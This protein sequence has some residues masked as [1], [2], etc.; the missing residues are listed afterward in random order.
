MLSPVDGHNLNHLLDNLRNIKRLKG[1]VLIHVI[2]KK[3]R[4]YNH[5]EDDPARFHGI[6]T[7]EVTTGNAKE[8]VHA[9]ILTFLATQL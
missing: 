4:E 6:S 5:A 9:R 7:F 3:G 1:P 8:P 2:T